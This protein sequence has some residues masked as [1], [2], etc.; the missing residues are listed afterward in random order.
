MDD[1][2]RITALEMRI[3]EL[4][5]KLDFVLDQLKLQ[6]VPEPLDSALT[7]AAKWLR[8]GNKIEAIRLYQKMTG[9]GL[10]ESKDAVDALEK[11]L[12]A[13]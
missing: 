4:E 1:S 2:S 8:Q 12:G 5:R 3:G 13:G 10:K 11:K 9:K 6:Y 7:E